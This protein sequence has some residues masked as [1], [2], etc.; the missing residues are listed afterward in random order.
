MALPEWVILHIPHDSSLI[1]AQERSRLILN[2]AE[3][4]AEI[5]SM[6]D[7]RTFAFFAGDIP[8]EQ[9]VRAEYS[10]LVVDVERFENDEEE[11]MAAC[12][13]G[14]IYERTSDGKR[15]RSSPSRVERK[16]LLSTYYR[17]HHQ[18]LASEVNRVLMHHGKVLIV[19]CHSFPSKPLMYELDQK[20]HR[21]DICIGTDSWHTP[22]DLAEGL[23]I[24]FEKKGWSVAFDA[25]FSGSI[26]PREH[27]RR[28]KAVASIMVEVN[29]GIYLNEATGQRNDTFATTR[30]VLRDCLSE[31]IGQ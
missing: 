22:R 17:P 14:A 11:R 24:A 8:A 23:G 30:R 28:T 27:Y 16:R 1:P 7:H 9:V 29:R 5:L 18:R 20:P 2:D 10:R 4:R 19:D 6:T 21:P 31:A 26:V 13:M 3:L 15:L 25:P 12:G